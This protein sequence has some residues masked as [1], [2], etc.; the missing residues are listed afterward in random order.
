MRSLNS[1][2]GTAINPPHKADLKKLLQLATANPT[3]R[4]AVLD[5]R[6]E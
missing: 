5:I 6:E 3:V 2:D 4:V 1:V